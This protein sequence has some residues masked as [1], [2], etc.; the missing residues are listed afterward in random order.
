M[1][2]LL[3]GFEKEAPLDA[4]VTKEAVYFLT[5]KRQ[6]Q[7]A[8]H[9]AAAARS[10]QLRHLDQQV[11]EVAGR[12]RSKTTGI[13]I[14]TGF[15]GSELLYDGDRVIGVRTDD[16]GVDKQNQ[17]KVNF[18]PGYDL[19]AKVID[20][21]RR[22][23][24]LLHQATHPALRSRPRI[25]TRKPTASASRNSGKSRR[26]ASPRAKSST[27]W[28]GRSPPRNTAAPG[29][30]ARKTT[31]SRSASSP[32]S[33]IPTRASIRS[34]CC[35]S[36]KQHPFIASAARRRQNDPLRREV[37]A[38]RRLVGDPARR[39]RRLDDPRRLR[40]L[41]QLAA[42]QGHSSRH[43]ERHAR[44]RDR[45]RSAAE[46][47]FFSRHARV[48]S[49]RRSKLSWIKDELWT[50]RNF[51]QGFE[52]GFFAGMFHAGLQQFTGGMRPRRTAIPRT[53]AT[54]T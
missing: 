22:H 14:F 33:T 4:E 23:A 38:L 54:S 49:R 6:V 24:R 32:D 43:Q 25:A 47:R 52:K 48:S 40:R 36:F 15:A 16:K 44:R 19:Q 35:K 39:R 37:A 1:R 46:E 13:T 2:E 53:P 50:V 7:V 20:P 21:R 28:A 41:P 29:F 27:P 30:T 12:E 11:C 45:L 3:P 18:E 31:S 9:A 51:H 34:T 8:H 17:P 5:E 10:R 26:A 42:P